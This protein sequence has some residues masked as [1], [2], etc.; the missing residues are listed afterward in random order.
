[1]AVV[2]ADLVAALDCDEGGPPL[3][4][5]GEL[6]DQLAAAPDA[7]ALRTLASGLTRYGELGSMRRPSRQAMTLPVQ[8]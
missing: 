4:E 6:V 8:L 1:V 7:D 5:S 3:C 2:V